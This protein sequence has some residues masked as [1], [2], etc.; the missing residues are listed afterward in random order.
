MTKKIVPPKIKISDNEFKEDLLSLAKKLKKKNKITDENTL[1]VGVARGGLIVAQ[2]LAYALG[3]RNVTSIQSKLYEDT[4]KKEEI[5][6]ISGVFFIDFDSYD[7]IIIA[8]DIYDTGYTLD[9]IVQ[10]MWQMAATFL[11]KDEF[12]HLTLIPAAV[13]TQQPKKL[14]KQKEIEFGRKI[15]KVDEQKPWLV[16]PWDELQLK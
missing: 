10:M 3:I 4:E 13:Y 16:F 2:Y 7:N 14:M 12:H 9:N 15:K 6:E 1:I 8:D 5:H 11:E